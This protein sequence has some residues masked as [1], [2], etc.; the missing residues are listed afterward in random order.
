MFKERGSSNMHNRIM[1]AL[2]WILHWT[3]RLFPF[4]LIVFAIAIL[5]KLS[6]FCKLLSVP[7]M[8]MTRTDAVMETS[9]ILL[10]SFWTLLLP[11]RGRIAALIGLNLLLSALM[12]ADAIYYR[13][14]Q[15]LLTIPVLFQLKQLESLGGS[16]AELLRVHDFWLFADLLF[17]IPFGIF[18]I[19]KGRQSLQRSLR[20]RKA[21]APRKFWLRISASLAAGIL[22]FALFFANLNHATNTWAKG[23]FEKNW[24]NLSIYNVAG[25]I[26]FHGYDLYRYAKLNW[27]GAARV[28]AEQELEARLW[29]ERLG[30][31]RSKLESESL[32]GEFA[33]SNVLMVQVESL[34]SFMLGQSIG[35]EEITPV[36]NDLIDDSAYFSRFYHQTAQGRTSDADFAVNCSLQPMK[37]GSVFFQYASNRFNCLPGILKSNGYAATVFHPYQGGFWNRN[38]MYAGMNYDRFYSMKDYTIDERLGWSLGD[39]SFYRQSLDIIEQQPEP[40]HSFLITLTSHHPYRLPAKEKALNVEE[41]EGTLM[42]DYLQAVHYADAALGE[43]VDRLKTDGLWERTI[44]VLYGDHDNSITDW[45]LY[46]RF[47][48]NTDSK[49]EREQVVKSVPFLIHL[50]GDKLAGPYANVGG[51][52]DVSP[53]LLYLLGISTEHTYMLGQPLLTQNTKEGP[54][55]QVVL[56]DG[57]WTDG[58]QFFLSSPDGLKENGV[59]FDVGSGEPLGKASCLTKSEAAE[60]ELMMSDRVI[61]NDLIQEF[62]H[63]DA[64]EAASPFA[65]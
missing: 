31:S 1:T 3:D 59:C 9:A 55:K 41:L 30:N 19:W 11:L 28:T 52:L 64:V 12:Y 4:D 45:S 60:E 46:D 15:D 26:G 17:A 63:T 43:L 51:Q 56:R 2:S 48:E 40:F 23:L 47:M 36:L 25:E 50:P 54:S 35:G 13:Y 32:F 24:W 33:G 57:S 34:Q 42:G 20:G 29:F 61:L 16:I 39:K 27:F 37:S 7:Y 10:L 44:L 65:R 58:E 22:G 62:E 21:P 5:I 18:I 49:L 6:F 8:D 53:T 38:M 14:F